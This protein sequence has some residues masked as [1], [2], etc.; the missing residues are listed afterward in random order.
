MRLDLASICSV[1][2]GKGLPTADQ[3]TSEYQ[4]LFHT[5]FGT[6]KKFK[7][8]LSLREG[9]RPRFCRPRTVP[10]AIKAQVVEELDRLEESGI[11][12]QVDHA[13]CAAPVVPVAKKDGGIRLCGDYKVTINHA[14]Q[15]DQ[16]S[17]PKSSD[18]FTV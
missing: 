15:V 13:E 3:F 1:A 5:G 8:H 6:L 18:L 16:Y 17:L 14:L 2:T 7:V 12:R 10:F 4:E 11:L 9:V